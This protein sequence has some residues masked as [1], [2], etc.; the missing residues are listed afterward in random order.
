MAISD[1]GIKA[2]ADNNVVATM[3]PGTTVFL[4]KNT[5]AP[6]RRMI[7]NGVRVAVASDYNPGSSVYNCQPMMMN[8]AMVFGKMTVEESFKAVTRNAAL[9]LDR[10]NVGIIDEGAQADLLVWNL[11]DIA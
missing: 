9:S 3:L 6:V 10:D 11:Q 5:F 8:F 4:G 7:D 1:A 2:L